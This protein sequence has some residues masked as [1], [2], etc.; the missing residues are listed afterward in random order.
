MLVIGEFKC[1]VHLSL[2]TITINLHIV[3]IGGTC[4]VVDLG[5]RK[6][7]RG[8]CHTGMGVGKRHGV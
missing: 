1:K 5:S 3:R 2:K 4:S 7:L 8:K 6:G